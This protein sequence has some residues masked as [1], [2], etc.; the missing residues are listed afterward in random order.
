ML[1]IMN[2]K[3]VF[4]CL[5][6]SISLCAACGSS[7]DGGKGNVAGAA[8]SASPGTGGSGNSGGSG[9]SAGGSGSH[10]GGAP[11]TNSGSFSSGLPEDKQLGALTDAEAEALCK[12]IEGYFADDTTVGKNVDEF[13]CRFTSALTAL[14]AAPETDAALQSS[15]KSLYASCIASP[16]MSSGT[17]EKPDATCTATVAEYE[18]CMNDQLALL[19]QL[20][21]AVPSCDQI[22]LSSSSTLLSGV[23][24]A[25]ASC[26]TLEAKCPSA[27]KPPGFDSMGSDP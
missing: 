12:R 5:G 6:L 7:S 21:S 2:F 20:G 27:P 13:L 26:Q 15:C 14:F 11:A 24:E 3:P 17:C 23:G 10:A 9:P 8:G 18:A 22:T 16:T 25:P 4:V 1:R 19:N